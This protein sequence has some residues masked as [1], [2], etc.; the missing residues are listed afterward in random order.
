MPVSEGYR[1]FVLDQLGRIAP[2]TWRPMFG[3]VG[4]YQQGVFFALLDDDTLFFTVDDTTRARYHAAGVGPFTYGSPP[5]VST[6]YYQVPGELLEDTENLKSW[7]YEAV[8]VARRRR[9]ARADASRKW[10]KGA[11]KPKAKARPSRKRPTRRRK[12]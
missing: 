9:A 8:E 1:E 5:Q 11:R 12:T 2:V 3:G 4:I 6:G 7:M 10:R